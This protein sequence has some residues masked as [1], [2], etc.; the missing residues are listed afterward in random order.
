MFHNSTT[1][2]HSH[3][4]LT[5]IGKESRLVHANWLARKQLQTAVI[6][7]YMKPLRKGARLYSWAFGW[8]LITK[9][10][11]L[12]M[13]G[14]RKAID[15]IEWAGYTALEGAK[16]AAQMTVEPFARLGYSRLVAI[17]RT[18]WDGGWATLGAAI[19]TPIA[20]AKSPLEAI[21][22]CR[23]AVKGILSNGKEFISSLFRGRLGEAVT[24]TRAAIGSLFQPI[25]R[26]ARSILAPMA[27][28]AAT[29]FNAQ[30]QT[31]DTARNAITHVIPDGARR[32]WNAPQTASAI[33]AERHAVR[34]AAKAVL[35]KEK[36][37]KKTALKAAIAEDKGEATGGKGGG[38]GAKK[39]T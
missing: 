15:G 17:K 3:G 6:W 2:H 9:G 35:A 23:D 8:P 26:P 10:A 24:H 25:L 27:L 12:A 16:G 31:V 36:E 38:G 29:F 32:L 20:L 1:L 28:A 33:M 18:L 7:D 30:W 5:M 39:A 22:G 11:D 37:E 4:Q 13:K 14:T 34:D 19:R 21:R